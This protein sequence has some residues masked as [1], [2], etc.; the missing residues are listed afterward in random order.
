MKRRVNVYRAASM[1]GVSRHELQRLMRDGELESS[2]GKL[3][4]GELRER[5][6]T[7]ALDDNPLDQELRLL[8]QTAFA[9]RIKDVAMPDAGELALQVHHLRAKLAVTQAREERYRELLKALGARLSELY[10]DC[11]EGQRERVAAINR[12]LLQEL[13]G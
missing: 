7:I 6:P 10:S 5:F 9:L 13:E 3:D 2:D 11:D 1:L 8:K 12:W 4:L